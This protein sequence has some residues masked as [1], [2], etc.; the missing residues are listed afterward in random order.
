MFA[1]AVLNMW[2]QWPSVTTSTTSWGDSSS[3]SR[4]RRLTSHCTPLSSSRSSTGVS[5][6]QVLPLLSTQRPSPGHTSC[7]MPCPLPMVLVF[8]SVPSS[9]HALPALPCTKLLSLSLYLKPAWRCCTSTNTRSGDS[10]NSPAMSSATYGSCSALTCSRMCS[11][12]RA[13]VPASS[14]T[15]DTSAH[16]TRRPRVA[17]SRRSVSLGTMPGLSAAMSFQGSDV[18]RSLA[19]WPFPMGMVSPAA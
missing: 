11:L 12:A 17:P 19:G 13:S 8:F 2:W 9:S 6:T 18:H 10:P 7:S 15:A 14:S 4:A 3:R 5:I 16:S 1:P